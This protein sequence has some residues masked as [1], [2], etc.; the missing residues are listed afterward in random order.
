MPVSAGVVGVSLISATV[1]A[2]NMPSKV[3]RAAH[4]ESMNYANLFT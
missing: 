2:F 4:L 3:S 1:A